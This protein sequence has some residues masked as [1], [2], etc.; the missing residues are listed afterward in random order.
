MVLKKINLNDFDLILWDLDGTLVDSRQD[1]VDATNVAM[2]AMGYPLVPFE[3]F[4]KMVGQ[5]VRHLVTEALPKD[6]PP[7]VVEEAIEIFL[8]W[9]RKHLA[10]HTRFYEGMAE[11][12]SALRTPSAVVSNKREELCR[13]LLSR[14][15]GSHLFSSIVGGDTCAERKPHPLPLLHAMKNLG[16]GPDRVLM[17]GDSGV[18]VEAGVRAGT[19]VCGVLW[20]FG[21][22]TENPRFVPDFLVTDPEDLFGQNG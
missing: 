20:G 2:E 10:D 21:D 11:G 1:L 7:S 12:I 22:P 3:Q 17:V 9:Y 13:S 16:I 19:D 15:D 18:D 4:S 6:V 8:S 14:L 5:G